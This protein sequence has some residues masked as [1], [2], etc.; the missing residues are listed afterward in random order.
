MSK[1]KAAYL[2]CLNPICKCPCHG[3][4]NSNEGKTYEMA[5]IN[6]KY[7]GVDREKVCI[8]TPPELFDQLNKEFKFNYDPCPLDYYERKKKGDDV[9]V[10]DGLTCEWGTR[11]WLNPPFNEIKKWALKAIEES[12]KGKLTVMLVPFRPQAKYWFTFIHPTNPEY[13]VIKGK[14]TFPGYKQGFPQC[15]VIVIIKPQRI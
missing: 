4:T 14:V 2:E 6:F 13:R 12:K 8:Q 3:K 9:S 5:L 15:M 11:N 10:P 7:Q 1:R